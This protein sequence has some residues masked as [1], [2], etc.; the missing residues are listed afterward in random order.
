VNASQSENR[1]AAAQSFA[2]GKSLYAR[3][4]YPAAFDRIQ[5]ALSLERD[6]RDYWRTLAEV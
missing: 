4:D 6:N 1:A 5:N 3:G 2:Q